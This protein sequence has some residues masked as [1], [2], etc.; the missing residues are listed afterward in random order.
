MFAGAV[1][2]RA[3]T[4]ATIFTTFNTIVITIIT[5]NITSATTTTT[6]TTAAVIFYYAPPCDDRIYFYSRMAGANTSVLSVS[7]HEM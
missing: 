5:T 6:T 4:I 3:T 7:T 1:K 2:P